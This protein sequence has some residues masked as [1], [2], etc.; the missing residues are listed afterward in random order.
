MDSSIVL[1]GP[2]FSKLITEE[3]TKAKRYSKLTKIK[4]NTIFSP[5]GL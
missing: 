4:S 5:H 1:M 3:E 2:D